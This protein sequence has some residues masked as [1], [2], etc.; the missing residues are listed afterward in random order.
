MQRE[1]QGHP[2]SRVML[3]QT[4]KSFKAQANKKKIALPPGVLGGGKGIAAELAPIASSIYQCMDLQCMCNYL[5]GQLAANGQCSLP[6]GQMLR[7]AIRKEYRMM[8]D[9]ERQRYHAALQT[10]KQN[11]EYDRISRIHSHSTKV[12]GAHSGPAFLPWHREYSKRKRVPFTEM[13]PRNR[14]PY[15][16]MNRQRIHSLILRISPKRSL[17]MEFAIRQI[18]PS[19]YLPYWDSTMDGRLA[20]P[21]DSVLFT[22][23]LAGGTDAQGYV[24]GGPYLTFRTLEG[25]PHIKRAVGKQ[26]QT[27]KDSDIDWVMRQTQVDQVM[28]FSAPRQGCPFRTDYNCLEYTHGNGHIF[29][30]GDM[31]NTATSAN[32]PLFYLH[33]CFIDYIWE[34]WRQQRQTRADRET[35]YPPDN[36]LCSSPQHFAASQMMPFSPMRNIDGLSN[37]YTDNLYEYA[38]RPT[39]S[40]GRDCGSRRPAS[41]KTNAVVRGPQK[42]NARGMSATWESGAGQVV[43]SVDRSIV[44]LTIALIATQTAISG[45]DRESA[46]ITRCGWPR[47]A[48]NLVA[49][50]RRR[51]QQHA[52]AAKSLDQPHNL[53]QC[54]KTQRAATMRTFAAHIGPFSVNV[55]SLPR[56]WHATVECHV[57]TVILMT[58][59]T[60]RVLTTIVNVLDGPDWANARRTR[61]C[62][63]I[64]ELPAGRTVAPVAQRRPQ[65][66]NG[67][68]WV[69]SET[70]P[71]IFDDSWGMGWGNG[72]GGGPRSPRWE[73][74]SPRWGWFPRKKRE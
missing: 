11:G 34:Q 51:E 18:D 3:G 28:A 74:P 12:G 26:G 55:E 35:L 54:V 9:D 13:S 39:C 50:A 71:D 20:H 67:N 44:L 52:V 7:K 53:S 65:P 5:R 60:D 16:V 37:K 8:T 24:N 48:G 46:P 43:V 27:M 70:G 6:N 64:A 45:L 10:L 14:S 57:V 21:P 38:P 68:S 42:E 63:K 30:G 23:A 62:Q 56:G 41:T 31:F 15:K 66:S 73:A 33:H 72:M 69:P 47:T 29:V 36:Q 22:D 58:I 40:Q 59:T 4:W 61:G 2:N 1:H 17:R 25:Q 49:S 32:D 19:L